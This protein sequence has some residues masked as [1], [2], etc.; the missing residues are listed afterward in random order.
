MEVITESNLSLSSGQPSVVDCT[1]KSGKG[2]RMGR[3]DNLGKLYLDTSGHQ[4]PRRRGDA[5]GAQALVVHLAP[6]PAGA[7]GVGAEVVESAGVAALHELGAE[8]DADAGLHV[9]LLG[10][11]DERGGEQCRHRVLIG[12]VE[13]GFADEADVDAF[14]AQGVNRAEGAVQRRAE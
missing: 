8:P 11:E 5:V 6:E 13:G 2:R 10:Q 4:G 1:L 9:E 14:A 7:L 12:D 3:V